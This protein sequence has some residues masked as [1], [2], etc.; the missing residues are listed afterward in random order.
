MSVHTFSSRDFTR[1]V[2]AAK[3]AA[4]AGPV[5]ITNRGR[6]AFVLLKIEHDY[7]LAGQ[8]ER[9]LLEAMDAIPGGAGIAFDAPPAELALSQVDG[10]LL[11]FMQASP[12]ASHDELA[13]THGR[14]RTRRAPRL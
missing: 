2:G 3:I 11:D 7:Q 8:R 13:F 1:D 12:L 10:S 4:T 6:A 9:T 14:G 5:V